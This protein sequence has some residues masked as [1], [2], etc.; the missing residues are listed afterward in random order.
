MARYIFCTHFLYIDGAETS[1]YNKECGV[2]AIF[3]LLIFFS[4]WGCLDCL[5]SHQIRSVYYCM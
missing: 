4:Q 1:D 2:Y 3:P 5:R